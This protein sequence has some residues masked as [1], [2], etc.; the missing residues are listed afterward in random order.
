M[1]QAEFEGRGRGLPR[2]DRQQ[3]VECRQKR[4][5]ERALEAVG[6][7]PAALGVRSPGMGLQPRGPQHPR[8]GAG[9]AQL[10]EVMNDQ[11]GWRAQSEGTLGEVVRK[12]E[13]TDMVRGS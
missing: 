8:A 5:W 12:V 13:V 7:E 3:K 11:R 6:R 4:G 2:E 10:K 9:R 1:G